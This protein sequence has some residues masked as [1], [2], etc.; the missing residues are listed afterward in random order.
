MRITRKSSGVRREPVL[1]LEKEI[2]SVITRHDNLAVKIRN[3]AHRHH[4]YRLHSFTVE[5]SSEDL[6]Q[7]MGKLLDFVSIDE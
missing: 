1:I 6:E 5:L 4:P 2:S 7:I 3:V